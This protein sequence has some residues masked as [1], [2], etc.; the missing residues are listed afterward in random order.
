MLA[1]FMENLGLRTY[2]GMPCIIEGQ[3][4]T[5]LEEGKDNYYKDVFDLLKTWIK[6]EDADTRMAIE[7][8]FS[9]FWQQSWKFM[10]KTLPYLNE[11]TILKSNTKI[12]YKFFRNGI[13]EIAAQGHELVPY[14]E[15]LANKIWQHEVKPLDF[16]YVS[17]EEQ[18]KCKYVHF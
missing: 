14:T 10:V 1:H 18:E 15:R 3:F 13:L 8:V 12:C 9:R 17:L 16:I 5:I 4:I 7:N 6:E 11:S 2:L